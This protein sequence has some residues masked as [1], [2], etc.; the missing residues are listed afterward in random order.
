MPAYLV[1]IPEN[2]RVNNRNALS[3]FAANV[4][5]AR[6]AAKMQFPED[7]DAL[8]D[9]VATVTEVVAGVA[10]ADA[11]SGWTAWCR[12]S[13]AAGMT[14]G[15][16]PFIV[17][18]DGLDKN[19]FSQ[20]FV[21]GVNRQH[22]GT[23]AVNAGG[24][25]YAVN[26]ILT[27]VGGVFTRAAIFRVITVSTGVITS[28]ELV[29]P[30]EYSELPSLTA[31]AVTGGTGTNATLDLTQAAQ[32]SYEALMAQMV[33]GLNGS[34]DIA[35]ADVDLSE[36]GAGARALT[37]AA[38]GDSLGDGTVEF[39]VRQNGTPFAP[40]VSTITDG[41]AAGAALTVAIPAS[42]LAPPRVST[43]KG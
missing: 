35:A 27:A 1:E 20:K 29:D 32:G 36:G 12:V 33:T 10:L 5:D 9:T 18:V 6:T 43:F 7:P 23:V 26:N 22:I 8:W 28:V 37:V 24:T 19:L 39:E 30:G 16:D 40:L 3:V 14:A 13:G 31:N 41:G 25:G 11:G 15:F 2:K 42:P 4:T 17:N 38:A 21:S 34:P